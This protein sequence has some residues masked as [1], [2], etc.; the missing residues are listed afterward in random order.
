MKTKAKASK[1]N[2]TGK[3]LGRPKI[4]RKRLYLGHPAS[5][6]PWVWA[7][8]SRATWYSRRREKE[9]GHIRGER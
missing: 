8:V 6:H 3:K 4:E 1:R 9:D 7:H 5:E 2:G